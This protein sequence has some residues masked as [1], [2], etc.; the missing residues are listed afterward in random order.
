MLD[1]LVI[2]QQKVKLSRYECKVGGGAWGLVWF[3]E[4]AE[5]QR[6]INILRVPCVCDV[7]QYGG[8]S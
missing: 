2:K 8:Q 1:V 6:V 4:V 5:F 3:T 7:H